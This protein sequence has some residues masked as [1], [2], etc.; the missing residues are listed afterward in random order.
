MQKRHVW[1]RFYGW[2]GHT[3]FILGLLGESAIGL[4]LLTGAGMQLFLL[5]VPVTLLWASSISLIN[6]HNEQTVRIGRMPIHKLS[7]V[8]LLLSWCTFPGFGAL[9]Y[10]I[11]LF[12]ARFLAQ[13]Q[14]AAP[15]TLEMLSS[16]HTVSPALDL[17]IQPLIDVLAASDPDMKRAAVAVL[18]RQINPEG[19]Q[20]LRQLLADV[21]PDI[22][23]D[24]SIALTRLEEKLASE[25]NASLALWVVNPDPQ[26]TLSLVDQYY[27]YA[28]SNVLDEI[29]QKCYLAKACD[30]LQQYITQDSTKADVWLKLARI[31]QLLGETVEAMQD[32]RTAL[33]LHPL[34]EEAYQ[35][36]MELAFRLH[37]WGLLI[38]LAHEGLRTLPAA[39][40]VRTTLQWWV[41]LQQELQEGGLHD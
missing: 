13:N 35:L 34:S 22:R 33:Q 26:R 18:S 4:R 1:Y 21:E 5:H 31:R 8:A 3:L 2:A 14:G 36:A 19:I 37:E 38:S 20:L 41:A 28:C 30:L 23:S 32:V 27:A 9:S 10:S 29:S 17:E 24:A 39:S 40:E 15:E 25:L 12:A 7:I 6:G 16:L 11:A